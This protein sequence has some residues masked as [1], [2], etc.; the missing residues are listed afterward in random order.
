MFVSPAPG[1]VDGAADGAADGVDVAGAAAL[2]PGAAFAP[3]VAV[4]SAALATVVPASATVATI[5][6]DASL[7]F[8]LRI[9]M[10][11]LVC[12]V[13]LMLRCMQGLCPDKRLIC[14]SLCRLSPQGDAAAM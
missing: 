12:A 5:N 13:S 11:L 9:I 6:P 3:A 1:A 2:E 4:V 8:S 10:A 14:R 7:L